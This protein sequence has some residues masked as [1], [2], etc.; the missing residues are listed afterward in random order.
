MLPLRFRP[1]FVVFL[2]WNWH[3]ALCCKGGTEGSDAAQQSIAQVSKTKKENVGSKWATATHAE[4]LRLGG[5]AQR[6]LDNENQLCIV[7]VRFLQANLD[8]G[9]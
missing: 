2:G 7:I 4:C 6:S 5:G 3:R 9:V 8:D 1:F